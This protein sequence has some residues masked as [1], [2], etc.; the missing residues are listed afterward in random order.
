M[1][2]M[3]LV[4]A[5]VAVAGVVVAVTARDVRV[6]AIGLLLAMIATPVVSSAQPTALALAFRVLGGL[7]AA[8]LLWAAA[9]ARS[10]A[11][12]GSGI[13]P[14]AEIAAAAAAFSVGWFIVPV[15]PLAGPIAAQ[16]AGIALI[17]IAIVPL[18]GRNVLRAG[19]GATVLTLG[20]YLLLQAWVGPTT[21]LGQIA[22]TALLIGIVGATSLLMSPI[23]LRRTELSAADR[24]PAEIEPDEEDDDSADNADNAD[25]AGWAPDADRAASTAPTVPAVRAKRAPRQSSPSPK[26]APALDRTRRL[27]PREPRQ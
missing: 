26:A 2:Q 7:L 23:E 15:K 9:R 5:V 19:T 4:G 1:I 3:A 13:G 18:S 21:P 16:A 8:Y 12:E 27:R 10:I 11:S 6:V 14:L 25:E 17:A 20:I 22:Q 24:A